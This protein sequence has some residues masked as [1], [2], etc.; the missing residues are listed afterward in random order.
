[1]PLLLAILLAGPLEAAVDAPTAAARR[2][3]ADALAAGLDLQAA[4]AAARAFGDF[5]P[6]EPGLHEVGVDLFVPRSYDPASPAPLLLYLHSTG[7]S[8]GDEFLMWR[9]VAE[10]LGMILCAPPDP[11]GAR[12]YGYTDAERERALVGLR[13]ARRRCNIDENR[14]CLSGMSRGGH[15][16][17]D[18]AL[19]WPD[20]WAAAA[21]LIGGPR[22][23]IAQGQN[24]LRYLEN[25]AHLPLR[26][27]QGSR[28]DPALLAN[29]RLAFQRL[30]ALRAPDARLV[31]FADQGHSYDFGAVD[32]AEFLGGAKRDP[33]PARV[34]RLAAHP[35]QRRAFHV[36]I[37]RMG[38]GAAEQ[39]VPQVEQ[40]R[41]AA[42]DETARRLFLQEEADART[43]RLE[44]TR[45]GPGRFLAKGREVKSFRLLLA[46]GMFDPARPVEVV[47]N[48]RVVRKAVQPSSRVLLREFVER[49]DRTFLPVAEIVVP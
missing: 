44:V 30:E 13:L 6:L 32:W 1:V 3:A 46:E 27:L 49:F 42:M 22:L 35:A 5:A 9:E 17:W 31:E 16:A 20:L 41:W 4:L 10:R 36:E 25:V 37:V 47:F 2:A 38:G 12:G 26:D 11:D 39:F 23:N 24:N 18:L 14:I 45:E 48:G 19:R 43:G 33:A 40:R 21:P 7:V 8:G 15:L 29:L 28:D 34:V